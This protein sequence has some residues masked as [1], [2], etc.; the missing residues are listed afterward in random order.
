MSGPTAAE[1]LAQLRKVVDPCSIKMCAPVD[2]WEMGLVEDVEVTG[3]RV[4]V[5][6]VLT[7][8]S[9]V[10]YRDMRRHVID[11]LSELPEVEA[12]DVALATHILWTPD[13]MK[14]DEA[15]LYAAPATNTLQT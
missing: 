9:C 10:F 4:R 14:R 11:V 1:V 15:E 5:T 3:A 6:L 13:R 7:D 12:V 2:I 8:I